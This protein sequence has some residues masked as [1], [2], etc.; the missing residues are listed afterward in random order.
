MECLSIKLAEGR[1]SLRNGKRGVPLCM[2]MD[3]SID[4]GVN[5]KNNATPS[6]VTAVTRVVVVVVALRRHLI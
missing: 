4:C 2:Q 5:R 1:V 3:G 6:A